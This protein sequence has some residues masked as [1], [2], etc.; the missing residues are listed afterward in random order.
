M[1]A[2]FPRYSYLISKTLDPVFALFIGISAAG[3]RIRREENEKRAGL[4]TSSMVKSTDGRIDGEDAVGF[5]EIAKVGWGRVWR[6][7]KGELVGD[8]GG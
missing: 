8:D 6:A 2:T 4:P 1:A 5:G 7:V 3:I